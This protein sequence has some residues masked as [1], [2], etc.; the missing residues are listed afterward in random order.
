MTTWR[1]Q[2]TA[3]EPTPSYSVGRQGL[4]EW[5]RAGSCCAFWISWSSGFD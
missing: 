5:Q 3:K 2:K 1:A 4:Q